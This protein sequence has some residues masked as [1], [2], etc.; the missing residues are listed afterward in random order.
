MI[1]LPVGT[2]QSI[3]ATFDSLSHDEQTSPSGLPSASSFERGQ[4][5][6]TVLSRHFPTMSPPSTP[7]EHS[8]SLKWR[9][10]ALTGDKVSDASC[11]II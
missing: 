7:D 10:G 4:S 5:G 1:S 2:E 9:C 8:R 11:I 3:S 6:G